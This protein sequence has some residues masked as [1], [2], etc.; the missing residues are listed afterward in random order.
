MVIGQ[1]RV[2]EHARGQPDAIAQRPLPNL[3]QRPAVG[4]ERPFHLARHVVGEIAAVRSGIGDQLVLLVELLRGSQ[5]LLRR[6]AKLRVGLPLQRRQV[7]EQRRALR[8]LFPHGLRHAARLAA[9]ALRDGLRLLAAVDPLFSF[10][11]DVDALICAEIRPHGVICLRNER[12]DLLSALDQHGERRRLHA[13]H[14]QEHAVA[15]R[16]RAR[17]VHADDPVRVRPASRAGIERVVIAGR[18][19]IVKALADR[20]VG[21]RGNPQTHNGLVTARL[22]VNI[23]EDQLALAPGVR[24]ADDAFRLPGVHERLDHLELRARL[25]NDLRLHL[26]RENRQILCAPLRVPLV[27]LL[28]LLERDQMADR[29]GDHISAAHQA[30]FSSVLRPQYARDVARHR[31]LFRH[32]QRVHGSPQLLSP[33]C[34]RLAKRVY[35]PSQASFTVPRGPLRCLATMT[36]AMF[37]SSVLGS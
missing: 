30:A 14:G 4:G 8:L 18:A 12:V 26:L 33:P 5:R 2:V 23:A 27:K 36:S 25:A 10:F 19:E 21:H 6:K 3:L 29:P 37:L 34:C 11:G 24:R 13:A 20:L 15:Q 16:I 28:R 17:R 1:L 22:L 35:C 9:H 32:N 31:R 7:V